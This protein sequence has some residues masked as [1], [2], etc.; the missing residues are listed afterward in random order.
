MGKR[1][2]SLE[3]ISYI[4]GIAKGKSY[5]EILDLVNKKFSELNLTRSN[6]RTVL[7]NYKIS[8]GITHRFKKGHVPWSAGTK[9][10]L[11]ANS[12]SFKKGITPQNLKVIG[13]VRRETKDGYL[14]VKVA[15]KKWRALHVVKWEHEHGEAVGRGNVIIFKDGNKDNLNSDNLVRLTRGELAILNKDKLGYLTPELNDLRIALAKVK[16]AKSKKFKKRGGN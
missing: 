1:K 6:I 10:R 7:R 16:Y 2:Y 5:D 13:S 14:I 11:T 3:L 8:T 4:R 15:R 9:G 12:G